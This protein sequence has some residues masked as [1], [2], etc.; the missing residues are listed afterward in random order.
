MGNIWLLPRGWM[1]HWESEK[2]TECPV[3]HSPCRLQIQQKTSLE[4]SPRKG[5]FRNQEEE[6]RSDFLFYFYD[7]AVFKSSPPPPSFLCKELLPSCSVINY[8]HKVHLQSLSVLPLL[9]HI[10]QRWRGGG[11]ETGGQALYKRASKRGENAAF[12]K[13]H[14]HPPGLLWYFHYWGGRKTFALPHYLCTC[15]TCRPTAAVPNGC[16]QQELCT[17]NGWKRDALSV[18][19]WGKSLQ[20]KSTESC[21]EN[22]T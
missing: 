1:Q 11:A 12:S 2:V 22:R 9:G 13:G 3:L 4:I 21:L 8:L 14:H 15:T 7:L 17:I 18:C 16:H 10:A 19:R 6:I 20:R 5:Y